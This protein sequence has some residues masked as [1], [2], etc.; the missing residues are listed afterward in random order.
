MD[1]DSTPP[2]GSKRIKV[3]IVDDDESF[4]ST[5]NRMLRRD[6][7]VTTVYA[8]ADALAAIEGGDFDV[9]LCDMGLAGMTGREVWKAIQTQSPELSWQGGSCS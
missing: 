2:A 8:G 3:L 9:I 1:D 7:E 4:L 5:L 6:L